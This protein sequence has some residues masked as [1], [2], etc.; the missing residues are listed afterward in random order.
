MNIQQLEYV[1]AVK[2]HKN[3]R[4]A[5]AACFISQP[6]LSTMIQ[7]LEDELEV[8]IF[9]RESKPISLTDAGV[10]VVEQIE[11]VMVTISELKQIASNTSV[12]V[13]GDFYLGVI[14]TVLPSL[15]SC[16]A[17][18]ASHYPDLNLTVSESQT[19]ILIERLWEGELHAGIAAT[20][21]LQ[22]EII[23]VPLYL[24][25][26]NVYVSNKDALHKRYIYPKEI[27][28]RKIWML[29]EGNCLN[30]QM[31][32]ICYLKEKRVFAKSFQVKTSSIPLLLH[33]VDNHSGITILPE[34]IGRELDEKRREQIRKFKNPQPVRQISLIHKKGTTKQ[35]AIHALTQ[36][37][38]NS[39]RKILPQHFKKENIKIVS[40]V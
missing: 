15:V 30:K 1:L 17:N 7:R 19:E 14:P 32:S 10:E 31:E 6:T 9:N 16:L 28:I 34:L 38:K 39:I 25:P 12:K 37:I 20:P 23:E 24:E 35:T 11:K 40:P 5:A 29:E 33:L 2:K 8:R 18:F 3:F 4:K 26:L 27:D 21:L 13:K 36:H 22:K